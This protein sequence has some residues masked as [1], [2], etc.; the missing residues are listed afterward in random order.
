M[1]VTSPIA[2]LALLALAV[3]GCASD[4]GATTSSA[5]SDR[6]PAPPADADAEPETTPQADAEAARA[7]VT[8][9][10]AVSDRDTREDVSKCLG[11]GYFFDRFAGDFGVCTDLPLAALDCH[12]AGLSAVMSA[13]QREQ[14]QAAIGGSYKGWLIDQCLDC[15]SGVSDPLCESR[16]GK[17]QVGT[18]IFFVQE[19]NTEIRGKTLLLPVRPRR[20]LAR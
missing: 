4:N 10:A 20:A 7:F 18:K 5:G 11:Q 1:A 13:K 8:G 14:F 3:V 12:L 6:Q 19:E 9:G 16:A 2:V 15:K 17:A